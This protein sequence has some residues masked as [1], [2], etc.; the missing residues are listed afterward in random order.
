M[1]SK[2]AERIMA[3]PEQNTEIIVDF[4]VTIKRHGIMNWLQ[5]H[6][7]ILPH[8]ERVTISYNKMGNPTYTTTTSKKRTKIEIF[9]LEIRNNYK[10]KFNIQ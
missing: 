2:V 9:G 1:K 10:H 8:R 6:G 3:K 4:I 7:F 5:D